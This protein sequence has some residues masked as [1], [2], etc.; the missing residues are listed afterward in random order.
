MGDE[1][2]RAAI[3]AIW[4]LESTRLIAALVRIVRDVA[5]AED[6]AQD[7]VVAALAQW[8]GSGIPDNPGAWLMTT[9][10]RRAI[11]VFRAR[12]RHD[13]AAARLAHELSETVDDDPGAGIDHVEDDVLRLMFICCH[14]ALTEEAQ[15]TLTLKLVAGLTT[16]EIARAYLAPE[17]TVAQR[18]SRAKRTLA[19]AGAAIEEPSGPERAE[20][21]ETVLGVVYLLFNEGYSA[22]EGEDWMRPALCDEAVRLGR[23]L[24]ALVPDDPEVLGLAALLELQSSRLAARADAHGEPVLLDAQDRRRWDASRIRRGLDALTRAGALVADAGPDAEP[25]PYLLQASIAAEHARAASV[26]DTDW[27]RIAALYE[28]LGRRTGSAVA[29]LNRAVAL[30]RA[31]GPEAGLALLEQLAD[32]PALRD[33]HLVPSVRGDLYEQLGRGE[34]A[35]AEFERAAAMTSNASERALLERRARAAREPRGDRGVSS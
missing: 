21:L 8:P 1:T 3:E 9:A 29:E 18:V 4:R 28:Q 16:R 35:A 31:R 34:D 27:G 22:T 5:L 14:P 6:V 2:T 33:Y 13:Q 12:A 30:G 15:T 7:A 10:K 26:D 20:R 25:G 32:L 19:E 17:A 24:T 11:D 23:I